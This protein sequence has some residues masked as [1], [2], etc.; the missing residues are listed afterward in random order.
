MYWWLLLCFVAVA[1]GLGFLVGILNP[2]TVTVD[3]FLRSYNLPL[4]A[5]ILVCVVLG[6]VVSGRIA[7]NEAVVPS[8]QQWL[9]PS[10][11]SPYW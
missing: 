6:S 11:Y 10:C 1:L 4:G 2:Q 5:L 9:T 8:R 3:L 7:S